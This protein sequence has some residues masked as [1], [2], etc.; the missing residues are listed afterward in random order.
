MMFVQSYRSGD[1]L[2][3]SAFGVEYPEAFSHPLLEYRALTSRVGLIDLTHWGA[4]RLTGPDRVAFLNNMITGELG[5]LQAGHAR[6]AALTTVKGKLVAELLVLARSSELFVLVAQGETQAVRDAL[7]KHII[8]DDVIL[9]DASADVGVVAVEGPK[10]RE[11]VWRLF[12]DV[13]I[14]LEPLRFTD[15]EYQGTPVTILRHTVTGEKGMHV[16]VPADGIERIR[17]YLVQSGIAEDMELCGRAAWNMRR[18]EAGLPWWGTDIDDNFPKECRLDHVVD[19]NKGCYLGQETLA[20]MHFRG[21]PNWLLVG[22][23]SPQIPAPDLFSAPDDELPTVEADRD[24]VRRHIDAIEMR[25]I[26]DPG[27]ELFAGSDASAGEGKAAGRVTSPT[28][29]PKLGSAL[30][31]GYVRAKA[32]ETGNE[33]V[34]STGDEVTKTT[35]THLPVEEQK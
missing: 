29:S 7:E 24:T 8:A 9:E 5:S 2:L 20:R 32:A 33:F 4:L 15:T 17:A 3:D 26:V 11:V 28:F 31:L 21:H 18:I 10:C 23:R 14:P 27:T 19:Y 12:P 35:I 1:V 6:H 13:P 16:I 22:L 25:D 34:F 30:F